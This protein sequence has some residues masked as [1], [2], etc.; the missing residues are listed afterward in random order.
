LP[1]QQCTSFKIQILSYNTSDQSGIWWKDHTGKQQKH[2]EMPDGI[3]AFNNDT[4]TLA[5][6]SGR[7]FS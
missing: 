6:V 2:V 5:N 7:T 3:W 4:I 1:F